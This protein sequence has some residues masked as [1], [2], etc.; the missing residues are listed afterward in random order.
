MGNL[1]KIVWRFYTFA[2]KCRQDKIV[3]EMKV[4][5]KL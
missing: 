2:I 4:L 5:I 3:P 1:R